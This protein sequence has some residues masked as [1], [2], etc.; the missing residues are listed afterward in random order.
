MNIKQRL[1][2]LMP[3]CSAHFLPAR[4]MAGL[5]LGLFLFNPAAA[6]PQM[7]VLLE[8]GGYLPLQCNETRCVA[9]LAAMCLQPERRMPE[10]GRLY[11]PMERAAIAV[12]GLNQA[13]EVVQRPLPDAV[14]ITA[15][16]GHL[17]VRLEISSTWLRQ[18]F[19][20]VRGVAVTGGAILKPMAMAGDT[21][22]MTTLEILQTKDRALSVAEGVFAANPGAVLT[23]RVS[24]YLINALPAG[25]AVHAGTLENAWQNALAAI[26]A[27]VGD[28][29][30]TRFIVDYCQYSA[31]IGLAASLQ[32]CLQGRQDRAL[33]DLH[34]GYVNALATGS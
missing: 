6:T 18:N 32:S 4:L 5:I 12:T 20:S 10:T 3:A 28:L 15:L 34:K 26:P 17:A 14:R 1:Q 8:S 13:A 16:R 7:L 2:P 25:T 11:R 23:A 33:E 21:K 31:G 29:S 19:A 22:P 9:E 30:T 27:N 24:N